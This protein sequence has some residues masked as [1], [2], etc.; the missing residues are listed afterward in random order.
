MP[1]PLALL[2]PSIDGVVTDFFEWRGAGRITTQPPLGA[3]WKAE[4]V[5]ADIQFGW[6][7]DHL[8]LRLDPDKQSQVRQVELTVEL[9]LQTPEQLYRLAFS[10]MPPGPDQF[11]LSQRLSG[12]SWQEI[13]P[14][15]SISHR[16]IVELALPFKDVQLTAGQEF[17]MT[18]L[19]REHRLEVARYPQHKPATFLV[20]GPEFEADLWRV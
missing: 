16:D 13:G 7:L 4:G 18:I 9:Q 17:R 10:L 5:L 2:T 1:A 6:N 20:P 3:M 8:Y 19:V 11:L 12:G 14:Y 15:A